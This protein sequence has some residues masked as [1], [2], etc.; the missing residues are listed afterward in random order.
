MRTYM[1]TYMGNSGFTGK[2]DLGWKQQTM[3][4]ATSGDLMTKAG[5]LIGI[6]K[7]GVASP[8]TGM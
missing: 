1:G 5:V 8:T 2:N 7:S 3:M 6:S 4:I